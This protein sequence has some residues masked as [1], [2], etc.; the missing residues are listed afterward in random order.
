MVDSSSK[1]VTGVLFGNLADL[2]NFDECV[3]SGDVEAE[4][5]TGRYALASLVVQSAKQQNNA[6]TPGAP[7]PAA[8]TPDAITIATSSGQSQSWR[9]VSDETVRTQRRFLRSHMFRPDRSC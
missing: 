7:T 3:A 1:L 8:T 4:G 2:G 9:R 6:T 5:F